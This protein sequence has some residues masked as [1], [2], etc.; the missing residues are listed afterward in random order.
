MPRDIHGRHTATPEDKRALKVLV[1]TLYMIQRGRIMLGNRVSANLRIQLGQE[2]GMPTSEIS[3]EAQRLLARMK[4]E[5]GKLS[6]AIAN[7]NMNRIR[8]LLDENKGVI[9]SPY[10]FAMIRQYV[11]MEEQEAELAHEIAQLVKEFPIWAWL[12]T[13]KGVGPVLAAILISEL[14]PYIARRPSSFIKYSGLDVV[15][16]YQLPALAGSYTRTEEAVTLHGA[17]IG[18]QADKDQCHYLWHLSSGNATL[19]GTLQDPAEGYTGLMLRYNCETAAP[20]YALS[21]DAEGFLVAQWRK[22][23]G[24]HVENIHIGR[25]NLPLHLEIARQ[26]ARCGARITGSDGA[27]VVLSQAQRM[28][29]LGGMHSAGIYV[30]GSTAHAADA[31]WTGLELRQDGGDTIGQADEEWWGEDVGDPAQYL[32]GQGRSRRREHL[33]KREYVAKDGTIKVRDSI[34]WNPFLKTKVCGVLGPSFLKAGGHYAEIYYQYKNRLENHPKYGLAAEEQGLDG[35][36]KLHRHAM[37]NRYACKMFL[38]D[39]HM[40]WRE[41]EGLPVYPSY[42]EAKLHLHRDEP[43]PDEPLDDEEP[44]DDDLDPI[45]W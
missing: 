20:F 9:A 10:Q 37:A 27:P 33:V 36:T 15:P 3:P 19:A 13:V 41:I 21:V 14:D 30:S 26:G 44:F 28:V 29:R 45:D 5:Y 43:L 42:A 34:T 38:I 18:L 25:I 17:G 12:E 23:H 35:A 7:L 24:G 22:A 40:R 39:L 1:S 2:P 16:T 4:A 32:G 8:G 6:T 31:V 11:A